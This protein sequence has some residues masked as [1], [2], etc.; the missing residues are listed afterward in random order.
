LDE[1]DGL[2]TGRNRELQG[3]LRVSAAGE[4]AEVYLSEALL[5]FAKDHPQL[6]VDLNFSAR[7]TNLVEEGIDFAVR[8]GRLVGSGLTARKL[9]DRE[10]VAA[11]S[12]SYLV[13]RGEPKSLDALRD[14]DCLVAASDQWRFL[15]D[16]KEKVV[17]VK[18]RWRSNSGR[19]LV[20]AC[21]AG[22]GI[23]YL[24]ASSYGDSLEA[25]RLKPILQPF[26]G[27]TNSSWLVYSN[28][29][30]LPARAQLAIEFLLDWFKDWQ[31]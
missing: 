9:V 12:E 20:A 8:Y 16:E 26:C 22:L 14:H 4:F 31:E 27:S 1:A 15:L 19:A 24:P 23:A 3:T 21:E 17:R 6:T 7:Y 30:H 2:V 25:G 28:Q 10:M 11:A 13:E 29:K 18:G 5:E